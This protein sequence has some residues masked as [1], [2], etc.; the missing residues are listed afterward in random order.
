MNVY[1]LCRTKYADDLSGEGA[2]LFGGR[3]NSVGIPCVYCS[4]S[5]SLAVLEYTVNI[6][7][8][9]IPRALSMVT[10]EIP[11]QQ[12]EIIQVRNLPGDWRATPV[13]AS[14]R[15]FGSELLML[16]DK[17][18]I[19]MPSVVIPDEYNYILNPLHSASS[20][21]RIT[22]ISDFIFDLRLKSN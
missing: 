4:A 22:E 19:A 15:D 2:R 13:P 14:T 6:S 12:V 11:D 16:A 18:V 5:R 8:E 7:I 21:F 17:P 9:N 20:M 1:R 3:W 10:I